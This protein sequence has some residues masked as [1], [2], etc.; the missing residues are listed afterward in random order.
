M[1]YK[2]PTDTACQLPQ[3]LPTV[4]SLPT[5]TQLANGVQ[6][7]NRPA[8][9]ACPVSQVYSTC[10]TC[11]TCPIYPTWDVSVDTIRRLIRGIH[12]SGIAD[13]EGLTALY[14]DLYGGLSM[15]IPVATV[16]LAVASIIFLAANLAHIPPS[17]PARSRVSFHSSYALG[18]VVVGLVAPLRVVAAVLPWGE[19]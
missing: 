4:H 2:S 15:Q 5:A 6:V 13:K 11:P 10:P 19:D 8:Y 7:A 3:S 1:V 12:N 18:L 17:V 16:D 14:G 9:P